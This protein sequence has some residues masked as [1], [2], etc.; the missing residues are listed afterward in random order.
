MAAGHRRGTLMKGCRIKVPIN[1]PWGKCSAL[2]IC[3]ILRELMPDYPYPHSYKNF[4]S[5][6][7]FIFLF[8]TLI[9]SHRMELL[10]RCVHYVLAKY[11]EN[12]LKK[13]G[14]L[15]FLFILWDFHMVQFLFYTF[16]SSRHPSSFSTHLNSHSFFIL[17][18]IQNQTK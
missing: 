2:Y 3:H 1:T 18:N 16:P 5:D 13:K 15:V 6:F 10:N 17:E 12:N 14:F 11:P 8:L 4:L 7:S 9:L